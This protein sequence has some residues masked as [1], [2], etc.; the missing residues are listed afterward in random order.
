M[1]HNKVYAPTNME[2]LFIDALHYLSFIGAVVIRR[3]IWL[4]RERESYFGTEF[5]HVG[6]IF[7]KPLPGPALIIAEPYI[8]IRFGNGQ[9]TPRSFEIW[10]FKWPK[11]VWSFKHISDRSQTECYPQGTLEE[12]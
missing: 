11:L 6:V 4:S 10:M 9:W 12:F 1:Q 7:Q 3:S 5:V 2:C 8:I